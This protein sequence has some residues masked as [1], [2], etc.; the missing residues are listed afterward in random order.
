[1]TTPPRPAGAYATD[2][3]GLVFALASL[4]FVLAAFS[5]ESRL[6]RAVSGLLVVA[7][8]VATLRATGVQPR[9]MR[10]ATVVAIFLGAIIITGSF[11]D[12][13]YV[14][15][16]FGVG[17]F[18]VLGLG[19]AALVRRIFEHERI[20][21]QLVVAALAAYLEVALMFAFI[22]GGLAAVW[23]GTFFAQSDVPPTS[24]LYFS[25]VTMTT[26]GY[27]DITPSSDVAQALAMIQ[28][29][30]GQ[31]FLVV[32]VAYL[33]GSLGSERPRLRQGKE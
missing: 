3:F 19:A 15:L 2:R 20:T 27:G 9:R 24:V 29:L 22:Y 16:T 10:F 21:F 17:S 25:V 31:I 1:M 12:R 4:V 18:V 30:F 13:P 7:I 32:L 28:T 33:V 23:D 14:A 26:L 6:V 8:V 11:F 5:G